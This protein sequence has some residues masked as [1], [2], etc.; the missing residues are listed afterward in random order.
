MAENKSIKILMVDDDPEDI[1]A[2]RRAFKNA[3]LGVDFDSAQSVEELFSKV[4]VPP[5]AILLDIN[6]PKVSGY[7]I[8]K[9]LRRNQAYDNTKIIM[10]TTST[11]QADRN[12]SLKNGASGFY[13]KPSSSKEMNSLIDDIVSMTQ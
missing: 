9:K 12:K 2:I 11:L 6:I 3:K 10:L 8:L 1:Y 7:D 4:R 13:T 5:T